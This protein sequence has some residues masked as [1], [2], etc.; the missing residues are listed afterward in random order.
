MDE[1]QASR[2]LEL[3]ESI[4]DELANIN[5]SLKLLEDTISNK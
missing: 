1:I 4:A 2:F 3:L 5:G